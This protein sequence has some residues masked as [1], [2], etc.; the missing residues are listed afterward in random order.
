MAKISPLVIWIVLSLLFVTLDSEARSEK[1][2][3]K[4]MVQMAENIVIKDKEEKKQSPKSLKKK[5]TW[6][7][8][9]L[10]EGLE[11]RRD[12]FQARHSRQKNLNTSEVRKHRESSLLN[13][14]TKVV[15]DR[16]AW[17]RDQPL[18]MRK[19][20]KN[21]SENTIETAAESS[22]S[23][24]RGKE[25]Y[26][27]GKLDQS[28]GVLEDIVRASPTDFEA[29]YYLG[30]AQYRT[31]KADLALKHFQIVAAAKPYTS[32][33]KHSSYLMGYM[34]TGKKDVAKS[35]GFVGLKFKERI[36]T[37]VFEGSPAELAGLKPGDK[38]LSVDDVPTAGL[39]IKPLA[40]LIIG[41]IGTTVRIKVER[42]GEVKN[43]EVKRGSIYK[44]AK[45]N[46]LK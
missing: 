25:L 28:I 7:T 9:V 2:T 20:I 16:T 32:I 17:E 1:E 46:W 10:G 14:Q 36:I 26:K 18:Y 37:K 3:L 11:K 13:S 19:P 31:K 15:S 6:G 41:P 4:L 12:S 27:A 34:L 44:E 23:L 29:H 8:L 5:T 42:S 40:K 21:K 30:L 45:Q 22:S 38:I 24:A 43:F 39:Q 35:D 33:G